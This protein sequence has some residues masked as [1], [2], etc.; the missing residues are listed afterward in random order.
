[1]DKIL[2][3][4]LSPAI[5][6]IILLPALSKGKVNRASEYLI[7]AAGKSI[8]VCR[9]LVQAGMEAE[10]VIPAGRESLGVFE[11]LCKKDN[12]FCTPCETSGRIRYCYTLIDTEEGSS[13]EIVVNEP[14]NITRQ[15][16]ESYKDL[17]IK[18]IKEDIRCVIVSG[19]RL[20]GFSSAVIPFMLEETK[21]RGILFIADY[22]GEDLKNS[23]INK[24]IRPDYIKINEEELIETFGREE[25][26]ISTLSE[27]YSNTFVITSGEK[28]ISFAS[29]GKAGS[30]PS[31]KLKA[32]NPIGC[33]DAFTAG[34]AEGVIKKMSLAEAVEKGRDYAARNALSLHPGWINIKESI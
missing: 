30:L 22:K 24:E 3:A 4:G 15:E 8:N 16:E 11:K 13:T 17:F 19:S 28:S 20:S 33:G 25:A 31:K 14:E 21:K 12:I 23:F 2:T 32:V 7:D 27:K 9:V 29:S 6:K 5:Q 18:K 34:L 1:M 10:A 26:D